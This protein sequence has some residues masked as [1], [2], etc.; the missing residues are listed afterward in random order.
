SGTYTIHQGLSTPDLKSFA[1]TYPQVLRIAD[2]F[3][4][5]LFE[6]QNQS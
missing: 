5:S 2:S 3:I 1:Q 6:P 4:E